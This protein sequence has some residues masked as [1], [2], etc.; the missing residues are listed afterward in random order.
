M[1]RYWVPSNLESAIFGTRITD[2]H[3][4]INVGGDVPFLNGVLKHMVERHWVDR[5]F[6]EHHTTGF[7][8]VTAALARQS[9][10]ELERLSGTSRQEMEGL[11]RM[12]AEARTAILVWSMGVTQH[13]FGEDNVRAVVNLGLSKGFVGREHCGLMPIRGHSGVQ[14]GAEMGAYSTVLPGGV[15]IDEASAA[16]FGELWGFQVPATRGL[17]AVEM[18]DAAHEQRLDVLV[19]SG[20]NFLEVLPDPRRVEESLASVPLRVHMDIVLS[21]QMLVDPAGEVVL[22]PAATRY[23]MPG[24]VTETTTER[25]VVFSPEIPGPRVGEAR[26]E[27]EVFVELAGRV[28]PD[29]AD[30]IHFA[31]T[32]Q[33]RQDIAR[34]I[35]S[36]DG[37]Q[38]LAEGATNSS[39]AGG[40][41]PRTGASPRRTAGRA[42][43][44]P[45]CP[46]SSCPTACSWRPPGA[47]S[48][49]TAW[50]TSGATPSPAPS[51]RR[52]SS[53]GW[54]PSGWGWPTATL[55]WSPTT[56][57][58]CAGRP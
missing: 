26:P 39:T 21:S 5:E 12:L 9:W 23:E 56:S 19:S 42:S 35:P 52:C 36:Y 22:L 16:R 48:S 32:A 13:E 28:R 29:L 31:S 55:L 2:R 57:A 8:E 38:A 7:G 27:W 6:I 24:G 44:R 20:G 10:E 53:A 46:G 40:C 1:M 45:R 17:T 4:P 51:A 3:F 43:F 50:C 54:T 30:R 47:A 41:W 14:G 18:I 11:A 25:R 58:S 33:I 49:S 15:A 34:S 37:I